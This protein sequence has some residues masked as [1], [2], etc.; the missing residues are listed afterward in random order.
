MYETPEILSERL[1]EIDKLQLPPALLPTCSDT[2]GC[3]DVVFAK[4]DRLFVP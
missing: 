2:R 3:T 4:G 1:E